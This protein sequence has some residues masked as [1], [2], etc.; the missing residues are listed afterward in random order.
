MRRRDFASLL[1]NAGIAM[2]GDR[3]KQL[4]LSRNGWMPNNPELPVLIYSNLP[5]T[6]ATALETLFQKNGWPP[7]WRNG[8]YDFHHYHST[9]HEVLGIARG[10][11]RIIL[12]GQ[13]GEELEITAGQVLVLPAGTGHCKI[14]AS[15]DF[16]VIGAYPPDQQWDIC[17]SAPTAES[18]SRMR[19]LPFPSSDPV[20]G[21]TGA[22]P[23]IW[24]KS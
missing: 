8:I 5:E 20:G 14:R 22:L 19:Q 16:L 13:G 18:Q 15:S 10:T 12:G 9:A 7:Q 6:S 17:R 4:H 1:L 24:H 3:P 23:T 2:D 11:A 21:Q